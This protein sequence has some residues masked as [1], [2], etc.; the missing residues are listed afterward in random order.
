MPESNMP[1]GRLSIM[2]NGMY[3]TRIMDSYKGKKVLV[4]GLGL[5]EGGVGSAKFFAKN[6]AEIG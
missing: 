3:N 6:G 5:N 4:F 2:V 1:I